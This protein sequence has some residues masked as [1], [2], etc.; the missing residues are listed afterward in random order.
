MQHANSNDKLHLCNHKM[1]S[2]IVAPASCGL[3][4]SLVRQKTLQRQ[5]CLGSH[6]DLLGLIQTHCDALK[7]LLEVL[8]EVEMSSF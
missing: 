6:L 8:L 5:N 1:K 7:T 4:P 3:G 2:F